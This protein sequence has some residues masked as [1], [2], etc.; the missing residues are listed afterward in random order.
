MS[1]LSR[2]I[3]G[4]AALAASFIP[5][6]GQFLSLGLRMFALNQAKS[7]I[8]RLTKWT[9]LARENITD[10]KV[11][12]PL[13]YGR[14]KVGVRIIDVRENTSG[15][16][17]MVGAL[18]A[19]SR[20]DDGISGVHE[21]YLDE[22][23]AVNS[24]GSVVGRFDGKLTKD[25]TRTGSSTQTVLT[26]LNT[27]FPTSWPASARGRGVAYVAL[28]LKPDKDTWSS[29]PDI[30]AIVDGREVYDPRDETWKYSNNPAL[31]IRDY[32]LDTVHGP[33]LDESELIDSD[34]EDEADYCDD[35]VSVPDGEGGSTTQ[36][37]FTCD[38][39]LDTARHWYE[40]LADMESSC[41]GH[42]V[43]RG[44]GKIGFYI[45]KVKAPTSF[46]LN[47]DNIVGDWN[48]EK[49]KSKDVAN[50]V[51]ATFIDPDREWQPFV[52]QFPELDAANPYLTADNDF[53]STMDIDLPFTTDFYRAAQIAQVML[54]ESRQDLACALTAKEEA[55][56]LVIGDVVPVSHST[57]G[58]DEKPMW[59]AGLHISPAG[60]VRPILSEYDAAAYSLDTLSDKDT[61]PDTN[62]P[63]PYTVAAPTGLTL[64]S[65]ET[66]A[67]TSGTGGPVP[68][69]K[70]TW[71]NSTH[72]WLDYTEVFARKQGDSDWDPIARVDSRDPEL[73]Y[74][75]DVSA[76]ETWEV[77][78]RAVN[79]LGVKSTLVTDTVVIPNPTEPP[80]VNDPPDA[81]TSVELTV[82]RGKLEVVA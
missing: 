48:F 38:G 58:W 5:G 13:I 15:Y 72:P 1:W 82:T 63:D 29:I 44:N 70:V 71:T 67:L 61:T 59:V 49:A 9:Q 33:G 24:G 56:Q 50:L 46:K 19:G 53:E 2:F 80:H 73:V 42:V 11:R 14:A 74:V 51:R 68:R 12:V 62:L 10:T 18:C 21:L 40:N 43:P 6:I 25:T 36:K 35:L 37:R 31:C 17:W 76:G 69:I 54:N 16:L 79:T 3:T 39:V 57:P 34:F 64:L 81:P 77:G 32:L 22:E 78:I 4:A 52:S 55:Q 23:L 75:M 20:S 7:L 65:D 41:L 45:R 66:T 8:P 47:E 27:D 30:T 60:L 28:K 26:A